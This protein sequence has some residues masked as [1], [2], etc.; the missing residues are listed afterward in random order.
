MYEEATVRLCIY[1]PYNMV[2]PIPSRKELLINK[3]IICYYFICAHAC[4]YL[5]I[6][7]F[8]IQVL[9]EKNCMFWYP[10][11]HWHPRFSLPDNVSVGFGLEIWLNPFYLCDPVIFICFMVYYH[12]N[13]ISAIL[14]T[15]LH[16][17]SSFTVLRILFLLHVCGFLLHTFIKK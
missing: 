15:N 4:V 11:V 8:P 12:V 14:F 17:L 16:F 6:Y 7:S 10:F 5:F 9:G 1:L 3:D 13:H 2:L